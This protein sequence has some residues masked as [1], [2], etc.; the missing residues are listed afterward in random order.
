M[1]ETRREETLRRKVEEEEHLKMY[2][3]L[4]QGIRMEAYLYDP[5]DAAEILELRLRVRGLDMSEGRKRY[6]SSREEEE[7]E[8]HKFA[9][10]AK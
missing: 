3:G 10:V 7:E 4:R 2:E 5:T 1:T 9:P 6:T 8:V